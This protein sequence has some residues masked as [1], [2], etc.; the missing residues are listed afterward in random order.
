MSSV[1]CRSLERDW[2]VNREMKGWRVGEWLVLL[3]HDG[4]SEDDL[5]DERTWKK[6]L[7]FMAP[8]CLKRNGVCLHITVLVSFKRKTD[9]KSKEGPG[10]A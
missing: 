6:S 5:S 3:P 2:N 9:I 1:L 10:S 4:D 7:T 8:F